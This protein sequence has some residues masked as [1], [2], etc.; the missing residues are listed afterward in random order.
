M[1]EAGPATL[2]F[3]RGTPNS[4]QVDVMICKDLGYSGEVGGPH[5]VID[6]VP[7]KCDTSALK[8]PL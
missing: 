8:N 1:H 5:T 2:C 7:D 3:A 6:V 4:S